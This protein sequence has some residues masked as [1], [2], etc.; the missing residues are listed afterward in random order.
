MTIRLIGTPQLS[1]LELT[2]LAN[3]VGFPFEFLIK[4]SSISQVRFSKIAVSITNCFYRNK[5]NICLE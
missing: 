1:L 3:E 5:P 4:S 2:L